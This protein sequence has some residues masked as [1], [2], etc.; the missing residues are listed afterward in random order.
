MQNPYFLQSKRL[1]FRHWRL[2]DL[3]AAVALWSD[4]EVSRYIS[5]G[6][7]PNRSAIES[8]LLREI[9]TQAQ[10][11]LQYWPI[12]LLESGAHIGCCGLRPYKIETQ[13]FEFG[14]HLLPAYWRK[15]FAIEAAHA[16]IEFAFTSLAAN[17]LFAGHNPTNEA[18]KQMLEKLGFHYT[19]DEFYPPTGLYHPSYLLTR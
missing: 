8:R 9:S 11:G 2:S 1:G 4:P 14:V 5:S 10:Y 18:S 16:V 13:I 19:H 17:A 3:D 6:G 15:G 12:F 7:P